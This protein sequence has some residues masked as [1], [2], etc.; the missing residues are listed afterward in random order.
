MWNISKPLI[1][2]FV[3]T[4]TV[5]IIFTRY[6]SKKVRPLFRARSKKYGELNGFAEEMLSGSRT[7]SAYG[8]QDVVAGRFD[9]YNKSAMD[10]FYNAE[11]QGAMLFPTINLINNFSLAFVKFFSFATS[12]KILYNS[13]SNIQRSNH[14]FFQ[15]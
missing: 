10:A 8:R 14:I 9:N 12:L 6:R 3:L 11:Y 2:I 7:I 5:S 13:K 4:V 1:L 15:R